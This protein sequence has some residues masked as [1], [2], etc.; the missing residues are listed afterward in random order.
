MGSWWRIAIV[1]FQAVAELVTNLISLPI[2]G[3][4]LAFDPLDILLSGVLA[5]SGGGSDD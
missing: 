3:D 4:L 1:G 5:F 2:I